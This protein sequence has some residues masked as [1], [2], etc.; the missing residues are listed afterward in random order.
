MCACVQ[1]YDEYR[2]RL[3]ELSRLEQHLVR[4]RTEALVEEETR[5]AQLKREFPDYDKMGL[6]SGGH[7]RGFK[8]MHMQH[9][10]LPKS[11]PTRS[12]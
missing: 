7:I 3:S 6:P 12:Q 2:I 11:W 8:H 4:A 9:Y 1:A 10:C 5:V